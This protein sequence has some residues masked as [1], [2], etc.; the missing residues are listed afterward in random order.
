MAT[1]T[2]GDF[3]LVDSCKPA[4][5]LLRKAINNDL[6]FIIGPPSVGK[7]TIVDKLFQEHSNLAHAYVNCYSITTAS[8][9]FA[10]IC[11]SFQSYK[12]LR[13][14]DK[15]KTRRPDV[16]KSFSSHEFE[17]YFGA[18]VKLAEQRKIDRLYVVLDHVEVFQRTNLMHCFTSL[19]S[20]KR[21]NI[22][23]I[24]Y[25]SP[26]DIV[27]Y[28][29]RVSKTA[30]IRIQDRV[31]P[32]IV[33]AWSKE[34][35]IKYILSY[36]PREKED[37]YKR[38]VRNVVAIMYASD[39]MNPTQ[40][41]LICQDLFE[42]FLRYYEEKTREQLRKHLKN[43]GYETDFDDEDLEEFAKTKGHTV[44]TVGAFLQ[45]FR[46]SIEKKRQATVWTASDVEVRL[47]TNTAVMIIAAYVAAY[48]RPTD[49]RLNFVKLQKN[50]RLRKQAAIDKGSKPFT[51]ERLYHIY[52]GLQRILVTTNHDHPIYENGFVLGD[53]ERLEN[54]NILIHQSGWSVHPDA[55]YKLSPCVKRDYIDR[56]ANNLDLKL[57]HIQGLV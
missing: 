13:E 49:D 20:M 51:F 17:R 29:I 45:S 54:L 40:T 11:Q 53:V 43:Q 56:L 3:E 6:I 2:P 15:N 7:K 38:F 14:A 8:K 35:T 52:K 32:V 27:H 23:V 36:P 34:D 10:Q 28:S 30:G 37:L 25:E 9:F 12:K 31:A 22:I 39:N 44:S 19:V 24:T 50:T 1:T 18:L 57:E 21:L 26:A 5:E 16:A 48:T 46:S 41:L 4:Y 33:P 55:R 42:D 47:Q